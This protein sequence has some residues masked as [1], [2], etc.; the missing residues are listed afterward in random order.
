MSNLLKNNYNLFFLILLLFITVIIPQT[1]MVY[2]VFVAYCFPIKYY[3]GFRKYLNVSLNILLVYLIL[4]LDFWFL[5]FDILSKSK[6]IYL[7]KKFDLID[8]YMFFFLSFLMLLVFKYFYKLKINFI[9]NLIHLIGLLVINYLSEPLTELLIKREHFRT[10][11]MSLILLFM[12]YSIYCI[13]KADKIS[14]KANNPE[15]I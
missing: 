8:F 15:I 4:I 7:L 5:S 2:P 13:W 11:E 1:M 10:F 9:D 6:L 3:D 12:F 14:K